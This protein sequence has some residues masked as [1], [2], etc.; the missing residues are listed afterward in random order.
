MKRR[1]IKTKEYIDSK[2]GEVQRFLIIDIQEKDVN[3]AKIR[4]ALTK[5]VIEDLR[6]I[7]GAI[8]LLFLIIDK[9]IELKIFNRPVELFLHYKE[10]A[11]ELNIKE[12][13]ARRYLKLLKDKKYIIQK[14]P[15]QAVYILNPAFVWI[16]DAKSYTQWLK[17]NAQLQLFN[18]E[19]DNVKFSQAV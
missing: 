10:I 8:K 5:A 11:K 7:N 18:R 13:T 2:T 9:A 6:Y 14:A 15:R 17:E 12:S 1:V 19:E 4:Q 16:G 3:F